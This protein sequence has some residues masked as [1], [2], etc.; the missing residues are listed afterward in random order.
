MNS[1]EKPGAGGGA[2][3]RIGAIHGGS[4]AFGDHGK[5]EST[6]HTTVVADRAHG[7]LLTALRALRRELDG[8]A[9]TPED[10]VVVARIDEVEGEITRTGRSGRGPLVRLRDGLAD[11]APA[12][13]T[14][15]AVA[16][17][18]QAV[19]QVLA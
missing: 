8:A 2:S 16:T 3:V 12:T 6:N 9:R 11:Y 7:D 5:A 14:G 10:D 15:A 19:A 1:D 4:Q 18:V 17:V 13:A